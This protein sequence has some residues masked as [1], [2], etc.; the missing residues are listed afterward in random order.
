MGGQQFTDAD[1]LAEGVLSYEALTPS[2][3]RGRNKVLHH[4][5]EGAHHYDSHRA[6]EQGI[7]K[8]PPAHGG[9]FK[10]ANR[11]RHNGKCRPEKF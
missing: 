10:V 9:R 4:R 3:G 2:T 7:E 5:V 11:F 8:N 1:G 6:T